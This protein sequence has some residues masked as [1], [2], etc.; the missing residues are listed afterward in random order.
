MVILLAINDNWLPDE[1]FSDIEDVDA[2][3]VH[4]SRGG[5]FREVLDINDLEPCK[6]ELMD[7]TLAVVK[8]CPVS[9]NFG[10]SGIGEGI[11]WKAAPPLGEDARFWLKTKG[12]Q[13]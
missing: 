5:F 4:V 7:L 1:P 9:N 3:I 8:E 6:Q 11:V 12:P 13:H 10:I 2:G